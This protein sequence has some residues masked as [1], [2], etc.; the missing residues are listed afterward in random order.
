MR[1]RSGNETTIIDLEFFPLST[2]LWYILEDENDKTEE[3]NKENRKN[4]AV[5]LSLL[6]NVPFTITASTWDCFKNRKI[7]FSTFF[8]FT[9]GF[10]FALVLNGSKWGI[11][12]YT[13]VLYPS[14]LT[15]NF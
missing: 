14:Y 5:N 12:N 13:E 8:L 11:G 3:K 1:T 15:K 4:S 2:Y 7:N 6:A 9:S 10:L